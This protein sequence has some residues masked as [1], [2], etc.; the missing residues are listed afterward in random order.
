ML[1]CK[2]CS[3]YVAVVVQEACC[4]FTISDD[5]F[6][7]QREGYGRRQGRNPVD[8]VER[9]TNQIQRPA[10]SPLAFRDPGPWKRDVRGSG[11]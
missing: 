10:S 9:T 2:S 1:V 11:K 3:S 7:A 8:I 6:S 5:N 4:W